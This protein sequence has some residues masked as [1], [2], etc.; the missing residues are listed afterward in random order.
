[1]T[2]AEP[3]ELIFFLSVLVEGVLS[4]AVYALIA[5]A[6]CSSTSPREWSILR[7]ANGLWPER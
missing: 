5:L 3:G 6:S 2:P 7:L 4:G 1:M